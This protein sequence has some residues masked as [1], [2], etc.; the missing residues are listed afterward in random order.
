MI[1]IPGNVL[2]LCSW[3]KESP[4]GGNLSNYRHNGKEGSERSEGGDFVIEM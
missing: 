1:Y 4:P 3:S 2:D